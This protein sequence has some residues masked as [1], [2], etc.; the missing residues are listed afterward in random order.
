[1]VTP[2]S[3]FNPE[4]A[5]TESTISDDSIDPGAGCR[6]A[7]QARFPAL[8]GSPSTGKIVLRGKPTA[9]AAL[10]SKVPRQR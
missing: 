4:A 6:R 10:A 3:S 5:R 9:V 7:A 8:S 2:K 1:M